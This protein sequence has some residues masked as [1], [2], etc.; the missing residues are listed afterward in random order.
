MTWT[1][2]HKVKRGEA[3]VHVGEQGAAHQRHTTPPQ[4]MLG[5]PVHAKKIMQAHHHRDTTQ[6]QKDCS[7]KYKGVQAVTSVAKE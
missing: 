1:C 4:K 7:K 3:A 2:I 6:Q 5:E